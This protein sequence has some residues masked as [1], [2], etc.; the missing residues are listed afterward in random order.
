[1]PEPSMRP[2]FSSHI[3]EMGYQDGEL[4]VLWDSGKR[5]IYSGV[6][7]AVAD[8][9]MKAYSIGDYLRTNVKAVYPH[10]YSGG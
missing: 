1:M 4:H 3:R 6:P 5:S 10:R 8:E 2:V 9:A 7:A